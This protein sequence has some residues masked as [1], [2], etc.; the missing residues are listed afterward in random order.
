MPPPSTRR[1]QWAVA[2]LPVL[3]LA[4]L[5]AT[6][7]LD[8]RTPATGPGADLAPGYGWSYAL[9]GVVLGVC[10]TVVLHHDVRQRF[11]WLLGALGLFWVLDG[12]AQAYVRFGIRPDE[13][14]PGMTWVFWFLVRFGGFLPVS[15]A[16]LLLVFPTGR[17]LPGWWGRLG[18]VAIGFM[19][20]TVL[21]S[22]VMP[23]GGT[24]EGVPVPAGVDADPVSLPLSAGVGRAFATGMLS[25]S[26]VAFLVPMATVVV[27]YR[28][29]D[30]LERDRMRW[31]VWSVVVMAL[32]ILATFAISTFWLENVL[33]FL[34]MVVPAA[35]M[36]VAIVDPRVVS[37]EDLLNRTVV[38]GGLSAILVGLDMAVLALLALV[39]GDALDQRQ[40]VFLVL[41]LTAVLYGPLRSRLWG[42]VRR[43][44]LG[45][46]D[47]PYDAVA[48][49]ASTLETADEGPEQLAAVARAVAAAFG[50]GYVSVE[51]DRS[52]GER[53]V[54]THGERPDRVRALPIT[55]RDTE[56][57][58]LVLPERGLRSRLSRR[59]EQLL[60]DL[61]RQAATAART[62]QLAAELQESRERLVVAR[63]EERRRIRRDLHDG[64]GPA[65]SGV[66]FQLESSRLLVGKDPAAA[67]AGIAATSRHVQEVVADVRR[68]V[69][70]LR[71]PALDDRGLVGALQQQA[72][73]SFGSTLQ[74]TIEAPDGAAGL[75]AAVE[76][77]AYRIVGE[78][79]NNV[80]RHSGAQ[81]ARVGL[82]LVHN[83]LVVEVVD[84]G[85]GIRP[86]AQAGVGLVSLRERAV[87]LGGRSEVTCPPD[88][89]TTVRAWL[90]LRR[91][92]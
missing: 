75:P 53:L 58:R 22:L 83:H 16:A 35:G 15:I 32:A 57:G 11:G 44:T 40:V 14:L 88:G 47:N 3:C 13:V 74:V 12:L 89:G 18:R 33:L 82:H 6:V 64:L 54:A 39:L 28:R 70:D 26:V 17:F 66:V 48:G 23:S 56:V 62:S 68:L 60:G 73:S 78:A 8:L 49:L 20:T 27:R 37:I 77:A 30:G 34:V 46:R 51:V 42:F 72:E 31:L 63:E 69:H 71:P 2:V 61:V 92:T 86:E 87:E 10:G 67:E 38:Y 55:Y 21:V 91:S 65:L 24:V 45:D 59:D 79:L 76:V 43:V 52:G 84:D 29:S 41:L 5:A 80:A 81:H 50:I 1:Q 7:A 4:G 90:P 19:V 85:V 36:T 9:N 25:V